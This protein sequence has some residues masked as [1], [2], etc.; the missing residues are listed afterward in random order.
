MQ[1]NPTHKLAIASCPRKNVVPF[2]ILRCAAMTKTT[3]RLPF[4][5]EKKHRSR[6]IKICVPEKSVK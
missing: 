5:S 2:R 4:E 6:E 3:A 1:N